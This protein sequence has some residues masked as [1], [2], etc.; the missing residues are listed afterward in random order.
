MKTILR[1]IREKRRLTQ[2]QT[3]AKCG[4]A[5][6]SYQYYETGERIPDV[7]TAQLIAS[8]LKSK[9]EIIFPLDKAATPDIE[10]KPDGNPAKEKT[11]SKE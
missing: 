1:Q 4:I 7:Y 2:E 5:L 10:K 3:S 8:V 6:R 11:S 9:V